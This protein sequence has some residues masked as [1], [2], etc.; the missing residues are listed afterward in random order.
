M[1]ADV[2][3]RTAAQKFQGLLVSHGFDVVEFRD[4]KLYWHPLG[5]AGRHVIV[6]SIGGTSRQIP[7]WRHKFLQISIY[8]G[9]S[10]CDNLVH[11]ET[12]YIL[13]DFLE[14]VREMEHPDLLK[15]RKIS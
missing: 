2:L 15:S 14:F 11:Q 12:A 10:L 3:Q 7:D 6:E 5:S 9:P 4:R 8:N 1:D 13:E